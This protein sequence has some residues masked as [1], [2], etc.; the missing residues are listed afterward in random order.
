VV[1]E[2]RRRYTKPT[3][4]RLLHQAGVRTFRLNYF[5]TLLF[6]VAAAIR[7]ARRLRP[8]ED[9][10]KSDFE[11]S[12]PGALNETLAWIFA[13]ERHLI[14]RIPMP[15]GVSLLATFQNEGLDR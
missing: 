7:T 5:N 10:S 13:A 14:N 12:H 4:R 2:H 15:V 11:G 8:E 3:L 1:S 6:P 9:Q